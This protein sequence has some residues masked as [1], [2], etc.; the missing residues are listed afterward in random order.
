MTSKIKKYVWIRKDAKTL[1]LSGYPIQ[2]H[3]APITAKYGRFH[4]Y[5]HGHYQS[6][7]VSLE[8]AMRTA[9]TLAQELDAFDEGEG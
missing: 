3:L 1:C 7:F 8:S 5:I 4:L 9:I 2:V 6:W